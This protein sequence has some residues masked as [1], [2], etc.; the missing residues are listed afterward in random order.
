MGFLK[1]IFKTYSDIYSD[2]VKV[3]F[4]PME[5]IE[6]KMNKPLI[7]KLNEKYVF[8]CK[9]STAEELIKFN[10]SKNLI[11]DNL[12]RLNNIKTDSMTLKYSKVLHFK[13]LIR[14]LY[15]ISK[16]NYK[17][18][19]A[20]WK[21]RRFF[22]KYLLNNIPILIEIFKNVLNYETQL[23]KKQEFIR[24]L[25]I[26]NNVYSDMTIGGISLKELIKVDPETGEKYFVQ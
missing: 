15:E 5:Y 21:Y 24:N 8:L 22:D 4:R 26:F 16:N 7:I 9:L 12:E 17:G 23:K 25:D 11:L 18:R 2:K 1:N 3:D 13:L 19:F 10:D 6:I 20:K 14:L